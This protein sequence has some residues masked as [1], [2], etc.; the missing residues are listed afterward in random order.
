LAARL[1]SGNAR[2]LLIDPPTNDLAK[3]AKASSVDL[4]VTGSVAIESGYARV[5]V[6]GFDASLGREVFAW[7]SYCSVDDPEPL[8][9]DMAR[10]LERWTA[11]RDF[12]RL[13]LR[14][15]PATAE[16][17]I[18]GELIPGDSRIA[19]LYR[20]GP[21]VVSAIASGYAPYS[22]SVD[23]AL[24]EEKAQDIELQPLAT[25]SVSLSTDPSGASISLDS[26]PLGRSPLSI[27]LDGSRAIVSATAE[28]RE[29]QTIVLP[30]SGDANIDL[31]L[32]PSDGLGPSGRISAAKDRYYSSL[33]W[34]VLSI[35][36]TA[37]S[38]GAFYGY[39]EAYARS[40]ASSLYDAR[41]TAVTVVAVAGTATAVTAVF[42][43]IRLIKYLGTA[44]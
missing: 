2:G 29:S 23:L 4:L 26:V 35:P 42:M 13:E 1:W 44:H 25:G 16:L 43:I 32:P 12:A 6:R 38:Y 41:N 22:T 11:G 18:N 34:F 37:L 24:G 19:Y 20:A 8:A 10:R 31:S 14:P 3:A 39:D 33:G 28:G 5:L 40:G 27:G 17:R 36:V 21:V 15:V 7:K 9:L 30:A